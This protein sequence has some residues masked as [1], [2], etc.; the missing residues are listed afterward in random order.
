M[1][2][3]RN[4]MV[5]RSVKNISAP[6][7]TVNGRVT[8]MRFPNVG[9]NASKGKSLMLSD[10]E[11]VKYFINGKETT[12]A[13]FKKMDPNIIKS[14]TVKKSNTDGKS[15]GEIRIDTK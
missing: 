5:I 4:P 3:G 14:I 12:D 9:V 8:T 2:D 13:E 6:F 15:S 1:L 7:P 10:S 11:N